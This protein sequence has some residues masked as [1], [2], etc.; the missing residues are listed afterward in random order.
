MT[1][2]L[3]VATASAA[4]G[5]FLIAS[6]RKVA[7]ATLK[8]LKKVIQAR[9]TASRTYLDLLVL[10]EARGIF[11]FVKQGRDKIDIR[12]FNDYRNVAISAI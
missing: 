8:K 4:V 11:T 6:P 10:N 12:K 5:S 2:R 7:L 1:E 9:E 3:P